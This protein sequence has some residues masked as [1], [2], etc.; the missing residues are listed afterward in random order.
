MWEAF[1]VQKLLSFFQQKN[2]SVFGYN[3]AKH[4]TSWPLNELVKLR[5]LW[6]TGPRSLTSLVHVQDSLMDKALTITYQH[7]FEAY[8][9]ENA[10]AKA[11]VKF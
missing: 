6:T 4:L 8:N 10:D 11:D 7:Y 3:V 1:A 9:N 5:M 2:F